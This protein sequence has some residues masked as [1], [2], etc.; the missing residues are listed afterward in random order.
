MPLSQY[1]WHRHF[2]IKVVYLAF[3]GIIMLLQTWFIL[4]HLALASN[5]HVKSIW[6]HSGGASYT[7]II[8]AAPP[9]PILTF[10]R[11]SCSNENPDR[12]S[13]YCR[14][15]DRKLRTYPKTALDVFLWDSICYFYKWHYNLNLNNK[16]LNRLTVKSIRKWFGNF[17]T[18]MKCLP[19]NKRETLI[20]RKIIVNAS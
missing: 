1:L 10:L 7:H 14:E 20:F 12:H 8:T 5:V 6:T 4:L 2:Y 9:L 17:Q 3:L 18:K 16:F 13:D 19:K 15:K 11:P